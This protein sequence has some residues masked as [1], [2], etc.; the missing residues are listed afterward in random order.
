[1]LFLKLEWP[2]QSVIWVRCHFLTLY[3][4][5]LQCLY[6]LSRKLVLLNRT[7]SENCTNH[8][9]ISGTAQFPLHAAY[10]LSRSVGQRSTQCVQ[11]L[12]DTN[13]ETWLFWPKLFIY[14]SILNQQTEFFFLGRWQIYL[15]EKNYCMMWMCNVSLFVWFRYCFFAGPVTC[16]AS[17]SLNIC[18]TVMFLSSFHFLNYRLSCWLV[19]QRKINMHPCLQT[20]SWFVYSDSYS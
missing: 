7:I 9:N 16:S 19:L 13:Y 3:I 2:G 1:M 14:L 5:S 4:L 15:R 17:S 12:C 18:V 20:N 6:F 8:L 11:W 10:T